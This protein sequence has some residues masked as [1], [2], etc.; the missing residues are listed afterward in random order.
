MEDD[1]EDDAGDERCQGIEE[2]NYPPG[3]KAHGDN[4][5]K[6]KE[7]QLADN[8]DDEVPPFGSRIAILADLA[9]DIGMKVVEKVPFVKHKTVERP[10]VEMLPAVEAV[11]FLVRREPAEEAKLDV[12]IVAGDIGVGVV[13]DTMLPVPHV[14][15]AADHIDGPRHDLV[16]PSEVGVGA[17]AGVVLDVETD[18]CR[19][20]A[21]KYGQR[22]SGI[23]GSREEDEQDVAGEEAGEDDAGF[24]VHAGTVA[25]ELAGDG[26]MFFYAAV[27]D[28]LEVAVLGELRERGGA[29][30]G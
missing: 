20:K 29:L 23:P 22:D 30:G 15:A 27:Q 1:A 16:D 24:Q 5:G 26:E 6:R 28:G 18:S 8:E 17:M 25:L 21:E 3:V 4:Q 11:A 14:G 13:E 7:N 2:Q 10:E 9:G 12:V 19:G